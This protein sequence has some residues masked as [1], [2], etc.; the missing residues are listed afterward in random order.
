M[1]HCAAKENAMLTFLIGCNVLAGIA[2]GLAFRARAIVIAAPIMAVFT[3]TVLLM[4]GYGTLQ[5]LIWLCVSL[6]LGQLAFLLVTALALRVP[7][8]RSE[9]APHSSLSKTPEG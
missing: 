1:G 9:E 5:A 7:R 4:N 3:L 6:F 2:V 8:T